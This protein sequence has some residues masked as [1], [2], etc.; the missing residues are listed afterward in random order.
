MEFDITKFK[1]ISGGQTGVDR[2]ALDAAIEASINH[3]GWVPKG[4]LAEDGVIS[5][6]YNL[7]ETDSSEYS[8]RTELNVRDGDA[9]LII[10]WGIPRGGT[11][12]TI[13][14]ARKHKKR[15][16]IINL[17]NKNTDPDRTIEWI[18]QNKIFTLNIAG[19]RESF[20]KG[21]VYKSA[22]KFLDSLIAKLSEKNHNPIKL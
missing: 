18:I 5:Q 11:A 7:K 4:R 9:T 3:G 15:V 14:M 19:P 17:L 22:K 1:I 20:N 21:V 16:K 13:E 6:K 8:V 10:T 2:A 12:Y